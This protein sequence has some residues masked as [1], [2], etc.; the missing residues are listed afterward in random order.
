MAGEG[1]YPEGTYERCR[2]KPEYQ[3]S[4]GKIQD[5]HW[6]KRKP[7]LSTTRKKFGL[8]KIFFTLP[9]K[10]TIHIWWRRKA[11]HDE[12]TT[13]WPILHTEIEDKHTH[14]RMDGTNEISGDEQI[15]T[16]I[17]A[18]NQLHTHTHTHKHTNTPKTAKCSN[19]HITLNSNTEC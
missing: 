17:V 8:Y 14:E 15:S 19:Y 7:T 1:Q 13:K 16:C 6:T 18:K 4:E 10:A 9:S 2:L 12:Q 5:T 3:V 11:F